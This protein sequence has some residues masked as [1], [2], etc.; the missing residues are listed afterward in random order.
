MIDRRRFLKTASVAAGLALSP[1]LLAAGTDADGAG[2]SDPFGGFT[3]GVQ[4]Y[5]FRNFGLESALRHIKEL[6]LQSVELSKGHAP[7]S[8]DTARPAAIARLCKE[9]GVTPRAWGV[10][11][12]KKDHDANR[13]SF[14]YG[15]ALGIRVMSANPAPD[16]FDS[17]DKL[18]EEYKIAIA[19]HPHGPVGGGK[20]DRWYSAELIWAAVKDH[21]PLIGAC[22]D[23]GH[24]IRSAQLGK[25]LDPAEQVR[26]MRDRNFGL[27]LK[28]HDNKRRTDVPFGQGALDVPAVLKALRDVKFKGMISIEYEASPEDPTADVRQCLATFKE[29]VRKLS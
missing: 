28:D 26:V 6:G 27:H 1:P 18:C 19:I 3:V 2:E 16:A 23:T 5:T 21:N 15:K 4:S 17:L 20:L 9:Y 12:F 25:V 29:S 8:D 24:L 7:F 13:K 11:E 14:E 10:Q 22:L